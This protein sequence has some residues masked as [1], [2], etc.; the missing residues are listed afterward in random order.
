MSNGGLAL[1]ARVAVLLLERE[2]DKDRTNRLNPDSCFGLEPNSLVAFALDCDMPSKV[3]A[4]T[5]VQR[6]SLS[7]PPS[8]DPKWVDR[9]LDGTHFLQ[10]IG[11]KRTDPF[12]QT[13]MYL[14]MSR[15][16]SQGFLPDCEEITCHKGREGRHTSA[17]ETRLPFG[18]PRLVFL[19]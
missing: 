16:T 15:Y 19:L 12:K 14:V 6:L 2:R 10:R 9:R 1:S 18:Y 8:G 7:S 11:L 3:D 4:G 13:N 17:A 5:V